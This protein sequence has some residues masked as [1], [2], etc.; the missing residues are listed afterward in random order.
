MITMSY[1]TWVNHSNVLT[2]EASVAKWLTGADADWRDQ[3]ESSGAF[4]RI[5]ADYREA[6]NAALPE[7]VTLSGDDFYGPYFLADR[8]WDGRLEIQ[9]IIDGIDVWEIVKRHDPDME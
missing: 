9:R 4:A 1:G 2:V 5:V 8:T 3:L 7:G 6:I